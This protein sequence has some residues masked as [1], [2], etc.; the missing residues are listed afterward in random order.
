MRKSRFNEEQIIAILKESEARVETGELCRRH[1]IAR[2]RSVGRAN[3][4]GAVKTHS[5]RVLHPLA[6]VTGA[7]SGEINMVSIR[8]AAVLFGLSLGAFAQ[9][10]TNQGWPEADVFWEMNEKTQLRV[11]GTRTKNEDSAV[12]TGE[13]G[14][15]LTI[16]FKP[17]RENA[18]LVSRGVSDQSR[19]R[20]ISF[21]AGYS[22]LFPFGGGGNTEHRLRVAVT[23]R[24]PLLWHV[25]AADRNQFESLWIGGVYSWRYRNR[26]MLERPLGPKL[27]DMTPYARGELYYDSRYNGWIKSSYTAGLVIPVRRHFEFEIYGEHQNDTGNSPNQQTN[28]LGLV[29]NFYFSRRKQTPSPPPPPPPQEREVSPGKK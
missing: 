11:Y 1:G 21:A 10:V 5:C 4:R 25:Q 3:K 2:G 7:S 24:Q 20:R 23:G 13:L 17:L 18:G 14:T 26:L 19:K 6:M 15:D 22:Y 16:Y 9:N 28:A 8:V 27:L 29:L 12:S